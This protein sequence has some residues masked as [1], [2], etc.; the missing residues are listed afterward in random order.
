M[1]GLRAVPGSARRHQLH[2]ASGAST[3]PGRP[4]RRPPADGGGSE[5]SRPPAGPGS[6]SGA[7]AAPAN[8]R[9]HWPGSLPDPHVAPSLRPLDHVVSISRRNR[10]SSRRRRIGARSSSSSSARS[11]YSTASA[12]PV[13]ERA[14]I[15]IASRSHSTSSGDLRARDVRST[16][17]ARARPRPGRA[18]EVQEHDRPLALP[19]VAA[20]LLA[21]EGLVGLEVEQVVVD[22]EGDAGQEPELDQRSQLVVERGGGPGGRRR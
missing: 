10:L 18:Q 1:T 19:Q 22:L 5:G 9:R 12:A 14:C 20:R 2:L 4:A 7:E 21:V 8:P 11:E 15:V 3:V 6:R 13:L 16:R 17:R